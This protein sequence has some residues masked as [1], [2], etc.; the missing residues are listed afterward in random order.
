MPFIRY[1]QRPNSDHDTIAMLKFLPG[2]V[3]V[4]AAAIAMVLLFP[5][6]STTG[7]WLRL[8]IILGT[9]TL[10]VAFWFDA[11]AKHTSKDIIA[12]AQEKFAKEREELR[13]KAEREKTKVVRQS[14]KQIA[15]ET[16]KVNSRANV[17][18]G[19]ALVGI[20][21]VGAFLVFTQFMSLGLVALAGA[22]GGLAGYLTRVRQEGKKLLARSDTNG[23]QI[24]QVN[25]K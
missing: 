18:V 2:L 25:P 13:V 23:K 22:G 16:F 5:P 20:A 3:L 8:C 4:Q 19:T 15:R 14:Q 6:P 1:N 7:E 17:K 21:G 12:K 11:L 9:L 10:I 24:K